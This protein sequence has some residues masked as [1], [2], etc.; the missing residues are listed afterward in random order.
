MHRGQYHACA[1]A[2]EVLKVLHLLRNFTTAEVLK[3]GVPTTQNEKVFASSGCGLNGSVWADTGSPGPPCGPFLRNLCTASPHQT[4]FSSQDLFMPVGTPRAQWHTPEVSWDHTWAVR[5]SNGVWAKPLCTVLT[6]MNVARPQFCLAGSATAR[7][8]GGAETQ[9]TQR[10]CRTQVPVTFG[11]Q[12]FRAPATVRERFLAQ[13]SR[14]RT[15]NPGARCGQGCGCCGSVW[16]GVCGDGS[17]VGRVGR[18]ITR[19][20]RQP[21]SILLS[22]LPRWHSGLGQGYT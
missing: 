16:D 13:G 1:Y 4:Q 21:P 9:H 14:G 19:I 15:A 7:G 5:L 8:T 12:P 18:G 22:R 3:G 20:L 17:L 11:P 6:C 10:I 2:L